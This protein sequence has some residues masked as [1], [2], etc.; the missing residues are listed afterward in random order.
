MG[1]AII[2]LVI[3]MSVIISMLIFNLNKNSG[4]ARLLTGR[5]DSIPLNK[6]QVKIV[7]SDYNPV[8]W[9]WVFPYIDYDGRR[10]LGFMI[11]IQREYRRKGLGSKLL[12]WGRNIARQKHIKFIVYPW[13]KKGHLFFESAGITSRNKGDW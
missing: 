4:M 5:D 9:A 3:G 10:R 7:Y 1:K 2:I 6:I 8:G 12:D 11:F 13:D